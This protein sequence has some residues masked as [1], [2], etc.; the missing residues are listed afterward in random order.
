M[1]LHGVLKRGLHTEKPFIDGAGIVAI[2][3]DHLC[4]GFAAS[5]DFEGVRLDPVDDGVRNGR[6]RLAAKAQ[7]RSGTIRLHH[8]RVGSAGLGGEDV[9]SFTF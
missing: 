4:S 9:D 1:I 2:E 7:L 3:R 8:G 6:R 5:N